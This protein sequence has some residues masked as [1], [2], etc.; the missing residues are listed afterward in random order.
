MTE[1]GVMGSATVVLQA[2]AESGEGLEPSAE[3]RNGDLLALPSGELV[4]LFERTPAQAPRV[5]AQ[6]PDQVWD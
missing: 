3:D 1:G 5:V 4:P 6:S 2:L